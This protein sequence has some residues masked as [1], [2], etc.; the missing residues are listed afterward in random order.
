MARKKFTSKRERFLV[1]AVARTNAVLRRIKILSNCANRNLYDFQNE[2]IEKIFDAIDQ[3][4]REA[5]L[6]FKGKKKEEFKL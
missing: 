3:Q 1:M 6:R 5:R 4:V 2:E